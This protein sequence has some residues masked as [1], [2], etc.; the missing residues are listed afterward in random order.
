MHQ[1]AA[2]V[3]SALALSIS[4]VNAW[5]TLFRRGTIRMTQPATIYFG[6]D[7]SPNGPEKVFLRTLLYSTAKRGQIIE[8]M[9]V[10]VRRG[11]SVQTFNI[12]VYGDN[13]LVR[14]SGLYVGENGLVANHHFLLPA[15]GTKF[16]F[17]TG[18]YVLEVYVLVV[19]VR[20][21]RLLSRVQLYVSPD[22]AQ[23]LRQDKEFGLYFDWGPDSQQYHAHIRCSKPLLDKLKEDST[24][25]A[26]EMGQMLEAVE[27]L[28]QL[29]K[30]FS[31]PNSGGSPTS[32][33]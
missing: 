19:N 22:A 1:T 30:E 33:R 10:K 18:N 7:P 21:P 11:E 20:K 13:A 23:Q 8:S 31:D 12:W 27:K 26:G 29:R 2:I 28:I 9:F 4:I 25:T 14:G 5:L 6:S 16:E 32:S 3:V 15:D 17:L 24:A